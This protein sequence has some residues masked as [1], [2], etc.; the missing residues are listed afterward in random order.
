VIEGDA[1]MGI[2][3]DRVISLGTN[4]EIAFNL[5]K[6]FG[7]ERAYP[8]DWWGT[9]L[10]AVAPVLASRF[11]VGINRDN[12]QAVGGRRSILNL[13]YRIL[14]HHD[15]P[16]VPGN[17]LIAPDWTNAIEACRAKYAALGRSFFDDL[18]HARR[19]LFFLNGN[20]AHEFLDEEGQR[21]ISNG[22]HYL[23]IQ[24][25]LER[26]FPHLEFFIVVSRP[27]EDALEASAGASRVVCLPGVTDY[28]DRLDGNPSHFGGSM[29]GWSE[30]LSRLLVATS[31][32]ECPPRAPL[33][34]MASGG[35]RLVTFGVPRR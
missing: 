17:R 33:E 22:G 8:F 15:F 18:T 23:N 19:A 21:A 7:F 26:L 20:G 2:P 24:L 34:K 32:G 4:C 29:R 6:F 28:G 1:A 30:A 5:R 27:E 10:N 3:V 14:H 31:D 12:L 16:R 35:C 11:A 13:K 9:P 25:T